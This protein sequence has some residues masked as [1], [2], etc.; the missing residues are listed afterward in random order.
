MAYVVCR[1]HAC[2][3]TAHD[4][5]DHRLLAARSAVTAEGMSG[6]H[7]TGPTD[8][9]PVGPT[10]SG[11]GGSIVKAVVLIVVFAVVGT[12]SA[13]ATFRHS[14]RQISIGARSGARRVGTEDGRR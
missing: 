3:S 13:F 10:R 11:I 7:E 12:S 14:E 1:A 4:R 8:N 2:D 6:S 5:R 9:G